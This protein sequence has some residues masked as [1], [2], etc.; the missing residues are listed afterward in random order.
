MAM[1]ILL[2]NLSFGQSLV[3]HLISAPV[4]IRC[5]DSKLEGLELSESSLSHMPR[6]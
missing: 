2:V 5:D 3:E 4:G 6:G 1:F